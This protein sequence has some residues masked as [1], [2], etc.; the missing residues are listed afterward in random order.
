MA[1][2]SA[3]FHTEHIEYRAYSIP[4]RCLQEKGFLCPAGRHPACF[5]GHS[6]KPSGPYPLGK[7]QSLS[8]PPLE[9]RGLLLSVMRQKVGKERSQGVFAP[10]AI[11]RCYPNLAETTLAKRPVGALRDLQEHPEG[12]LLGFSP[13][14]LEPGLRAKKRVSQFGLPHPVGAQ[15]SRGESISFLSPAQ[16]AGALTFCYAAES[17]QRSQPRGLHPPWLTPAGA[18]ELSQALLRADASGA[19]QSKLQSSGAE[20]HLAPPGVAGA[21]ATLRVAIS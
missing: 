15:P 7:N 19:L 3:W 21:R 2:C 14:N 9:P 8:S 11:P 1:F 13:P 16:A 4:L 18:T 20:R 6:V 5:R 10:L 17:K 12:V